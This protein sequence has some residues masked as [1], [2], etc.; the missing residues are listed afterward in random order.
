MEC[1]ICNQNIFD[2]RINIFNPSCGCS[3]Y[4]DTD[5]LLT[6]L[7]KDRDCAFHISSFKKVD[8]GFII[9]QCECITHLDEIE[10]LNYR[11]KCPLCRENVIASKINVDLYNYYCCNNKKYKCEFCLKSLTY[12]EHIKHKNICEE[13]E[14]LCPKKKCNQIIKRKNLIFHL[15][16][17]CEFCFTKC[18]YC[19]TKIKCKDIIKHQQICHIKYCLII[20]INRKVGL[21]MNLQNLGYI[22]LNNDVIIEGTIIDTFNNINNIILIEYK[23]VFDN[24][25]YIL[26][27]IENL[28]S[29]S[30]INY[31]KLDYEDEIINYNNNY[32]KQKYY[33]IYKEIN[34]IIDSILN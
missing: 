12:T 24:S 19:F 32:G 34:N 30:Q 29:P 27:E 2:K 14:I 11:F 7:F 28:K 25:K 20:E 9:F 5:C 6:L 22:N 21:N 1:I 26:I 10:L 15:K 17:E 4:F 23:D 31:N 13:Y 18:N 8:S 33:F 3:I 16:N